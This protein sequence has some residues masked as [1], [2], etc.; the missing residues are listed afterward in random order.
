MGK[1]KN[2][3]RSFSQT[4]LQEMSLDSLRENREFFSG[5]IDNVNQ[6]LAQYK[7]RGSPEEEAGWRRSACGARRHLS[8]QLS[9]VKR[10]LARRTSEGETGKAKLKRALI[11]A[12]LAVEIGMD[13][14]KG[15][16]EMLD[17]RVEDC[18][19]AADVIA[20]SWE[21]VFVESQDY[22]DPEVGEG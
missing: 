22:E 4:Q 8:H 16:P 14:L 7:E 20:N 9:N 6:Q 11:P 3:R 12:L 1:R 2:E 19:E 17:D 10:E 15:T 21:R 18:L 13:A 5:E